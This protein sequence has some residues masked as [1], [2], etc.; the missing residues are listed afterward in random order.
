[1][2]QGGEAVSAACRIQLDLA[3]GSVEGHSDRV[4][5]CVAVLSSPSRGVWA[6]PETESNLA[7]ASYSREL[8]GGKQ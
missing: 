8:A 6:N 2:N 1:M 4:R 7:A 5:L 3:S